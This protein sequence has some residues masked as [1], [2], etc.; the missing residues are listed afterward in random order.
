MAPPKVTSHTSLPSQMGPIELMTMRRSRSV[1]ASGDRM[2][3]P[4]SKPSRTA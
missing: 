3:T 4:K 1:R 2:P